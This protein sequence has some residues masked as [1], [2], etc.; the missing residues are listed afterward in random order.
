M[1]FLKKRFWG[2]AFSV[3]SLCLFCILLSSFNQT[4]IN[5]NVENAENTE[6]RALNDE[7]KPSF[8]SGTATKET[9]KYMVIIEGSDLCTYKIS[10]GTKT[11]LRKSGFGPILLTSDDI[12]KLEDGI[13]S[14]N[15]EDIYLYYEA[16][17]S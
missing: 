15:L 7:V 9:E 17:A 8:T 5:S 10:N 3:I 11:L 16:Y 4:D 1:N 12:K 14:D 6:E 2:L 13:Y